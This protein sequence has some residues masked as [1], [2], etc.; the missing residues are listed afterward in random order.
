MEDVKET[1]TVKWPPESGPLPLKKHAPKPL[2]SP[3]SLSICSFNILADSYCSPR[4]HRNLP[5]A[6]FVFNSKKRL[7]LLQDTL[8]RFSETFDVICLQEV[9]VFDDV[10]NPVMVEL[11]YKGICVKRE[12]DRMDGCVIFYRHSV[13]TCIESESIFFDDL[14]LL[15]RVQDNVTF[16]EPGK[17]AFNPNGSL[18]GIVRSLIRKNAAALVILEHISNKQRVA[19]S[20]AHLYWNPGYEYVKLAQSKYL[21][22]RIYAIAKRNSPNPID[23]VMPVIICGDFNAKPGSF[24]YEFLSKGIIDGRKAAPWRYFPD[25][26]Y[27]DSF[28]SMT[29]LSINDSCLS[30]KVEELSIQEEKDNGTR[31]S[32]TTYSEE[33]VLR[34]TNTSDLP[35]RNG[36]WKRSNTSEGSFLDSSSRKSSSDVKYLLDFSLNKL[37]RWLRIFGFDAVMETEEEENER[38][39]QKGTVLIFKRCLEEKRTLVTTS[40]KLLLRKDCPPGAFLVDFRNLEE[41]FTHLLLTHGS[42]LEP[43]RFL[44]KCTVCNG[45]ITEVICEHKKESLF[46]S[47]KAPNDPNICLY[48]CNDCS[49]P[50]WW[51][52]RPDSSASRVKNKAGELFKL[53]LRAGVPIKGE[54]SVFDFVDV[55][56]ERELGR[57]IYSTTY[58]TLEVIHWLKQAELKH[59]FKLKPVYDNISFT[60]VTNDFVGALDHIFYE[61]DKWEMLQSLYLPRSFNELNYS[62]VPNGHLLPSQ[63]WPSDHL[64]VGAVFAFKPKPK[65]RNDC[66]CG[67]LPKNVFSLFEMAEMRKKA[68]AK[69]ESKAHQPGADK[70]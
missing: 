63:K 28:A 60:N 59:P 3:F 67:C 38:T 14:A 66:G 69:K 45:K 41:A 46:L 27:Q 2:S 8:R 64:P 40:N 10:V 26:I 19:V 30:Q 56:A 42:I 25:D 7:K 53:A 5:D 65:H 1:L 11:G 17:G 24:A 49:Q 16:N 35:S 48:S 44:T 22:D 9:D 31:I 62:G 68:R 37:C 58:T 20:S 39:R 61:I 57:S 4:S 43:S 47:V 36:Q 12:G 52:E 34:W 51:S 21:T 15:E 70:W 55:E 6:D 18:F 50:Y 54:L 23:D 32:E 29:T 33:T 13:W